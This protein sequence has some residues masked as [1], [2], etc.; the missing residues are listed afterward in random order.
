[1]EAAILDVVVIGAGLAGLMAGWQAALKGC[2][3]RVVAKGWGTTHWH[4]G[5]I[6]VLGYYPADSPT[7]VEVPAE[8]LAE[9]VRTT[10]RHPYALIGIQ[11]LAHALE[12]FQQLCAAAGYP[13]HG[14]LERNWLLPTALGGVR[15]TCLAPET[16]IAGDLRQR[17]PLLLVGFRPY[18]DFYPA[19][20]AD[21]LKVQ[22]FPARDVTLDLPRPEQRRL[23]N[24]T[25]LAQLFERADFRAE[26]AEALKPHLGDVARVGFPAVLGVHHA[27]DV[28]RDLQARLGRPVFEIPV[29]PPSIPGMRLHHI[30]TSA[31][32]RAGGR[33]FEGM[34]VVAADVRDKTVEAVW[35]QAAAR[36][37][38]HR[39]RHFV[40]ATGGILGSGIVAAD[41][42]T[43]REVVFN[44][45]LAGVP[46]HRDWFD[47]E[48]LSLRGHP[49]YR[50][51]VAVNARLQPLD[52][53]DNVLYTNLY[54]AGTTLAYCDTLLER[55]FE[56]VA[57]GTGFVAA[58]Q[59][60]AKS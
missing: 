55:S 19:L 6:D 4:A 31:I 48:F 53:A 20:A 43:L 41:M 9:L 25:T 30:L 37:K 40:L 7:P 2:Q 57:L 59:C 38:S 24:A 8:A 39:A 47:A 15:P 58:Q 18:L 17:D 26:V 21:N 1:M 29:L 56:G 51:G 45:P 44:L 34:E 33:V 50:A 14:S 23:V 3:V 52:A 16:M 10:P 11:A 54:V 32:E 27:L 28:Q 13:L 42:E 12:A 60:T 35:T 22:G 49:I 5:C 36:R 46:E